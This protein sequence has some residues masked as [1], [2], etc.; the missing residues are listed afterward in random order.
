MK[1]L[2]R[3]KKGE[4]VE[5]ERMRRKKMGEKEPLQAATGEGRGRRR[6]QNGDEK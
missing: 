6:G 5:E 4:E 3:K 2:G 1:E